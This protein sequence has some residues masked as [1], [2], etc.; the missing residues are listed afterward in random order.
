MH[1]I[2]RL[3]CIDILFNKYSNLL[4]NDNEINYFRNVSEIKY[5][6]FNNTQF[7]FDKSM[8]GLLEY[9]S[10]RQDLHQNCCS[11]DEDD[12]K[13]KDKDKGDDDD[14]DEEEDDDDDD[15]DI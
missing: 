7:P 11:D 3:D 10:V 4:L 12:H 8:D 1:K 6:L 2:C 13:D 14:E 5:N 15:L 9:F